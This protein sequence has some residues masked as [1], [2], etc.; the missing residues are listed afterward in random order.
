MISHVSGWQKLGKMYSTTYSPGNTI[1]C[2][3]LFRYVCRY[4][5]V[6]QYATTAEGLYLKPIKLFSIGHKPLLIPW[7]AIENYESGNFLLFYASRFRIKGI[8]I[9]INHELSALRTI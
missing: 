1:S 7:E 4:S 8:T 5:G 3:A 6:L 9:L 2:S